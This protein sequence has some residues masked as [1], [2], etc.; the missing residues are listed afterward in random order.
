MSEI[1]ELIEQEV[2][3]RLCPDCG[4]HFNIHAP[5]CPYC[6]EINE[7]G[8]EEAYLRDLD[9]IREKLDKAKNIPKETLKKEAKFQGKRILKVFLFVIIVTAIGVSIYFYYSNKEKKDAEKQYL[10]QHA[11]QQENYPLLDEMFDEGKYDE[12]VQFAN[13]LYLS[14]ETNGTGFSI[15]SWQHYQWYTAYERY[16]NAKDYYEDESKQKNYGIDSKTFI[17]YDAMYIFVEAWETKLNTVGNLTKEDY[18]LILSYQEE[19]RSLMMECYK[20]TNEDID[21]M[22]QLVAFDPPG[23][24]TDF[25]KCEKIYLERFEG[26]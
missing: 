11:W 23:V 13:N 14:N 5:K 10:E 20:I 17:F 15:W 4:A 9:A 26:M 19:L 1:S 16:K 8:D 3:D 24:G 18:D 21:E 7:F 6:G 2:Q 25:K 12:I 22:I